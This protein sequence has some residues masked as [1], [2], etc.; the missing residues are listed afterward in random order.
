MCSYFYSAESHRL[1]NIRTMCLQWLLNNMITQCSEELLRE[2]TLDLMKEIIASSE[3]LMMEVEMDVYTMLKKW[4]FLQ[5]P[6]TWWGLRSALLPHTDLWF[7][8]SRRESEGTPFLETEQG[9]AFVPVFQQLQLAYII[10]DLTSV[11]VIH[12]DALIPA[13]WLSQVYK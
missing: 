10:W 1:Q 2:A 9:R 7:A 4:M 6:P 3:L 5:L 8:R 12:Q 13:A 11:H